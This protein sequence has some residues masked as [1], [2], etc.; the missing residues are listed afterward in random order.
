MIS[1][2]KYDA[3]V[4]GYVSMD[5]IIKVDT[6][7]QAGYTSLIT[8]ADHAKI[9]YGGCSVNISV[10]LCK[11]GL[12]AL[13]L[14]RVGPDYEPNGFK[15]F[16]QAANVPLDG[17]TVLDN[18]TTSSCYLLQDNQN[19]HITIFYPG[20]MAKKY[21]APAAD[22]LFANARLGIMTVASKPDNEFFLRQCQ[23]HHVPLAFGMKDDFDAF[24]PEFLTKVLRASQ[25]IF[26][27]EKERS[28]VEDLLGCDTTKLITHGDAIAI[29]TTLGECG[30]VCYTK[31]DMGRL[32]KHEINVC[33]VDKVV[34]AT[35][36]G[37]AY[38]AGFLYGYQKGRSIRE[39]CCLG[40][41]L[42]SFVLG[43][44]GCC[45]GLPDAQALET[46]MR[47]RFERE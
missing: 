27:N 12:T 8:N 25:F 15:A 5:H 47:E 36:A 18:E 19:N 38:M 41:A 10:A 32:V 21:A 33:P 28:V 14:L 35:G 45:T 37:D 4:S 6:P 44:I 40:A 46:K 29:I 11:L 1:N 34:D 39:C 31:N 24:P 2:M 17:I 3:L 16:L 42:S 22:E 43:E 9:Y 7:V 20:A 23:Q 13:P 26:M 30:S